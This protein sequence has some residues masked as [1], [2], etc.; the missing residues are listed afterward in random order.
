MTHTVYIQ[1]GIGEDLSEKK[2]LKCHWKLSSIMNVI[3]AFRYQAETGKDF[4]GRLLD[5]L[6]NES[7]KAKYIIDHNYFIA[8]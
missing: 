2:T 6:E 5:A 1:E 7:F 8:W 4:C 3:V